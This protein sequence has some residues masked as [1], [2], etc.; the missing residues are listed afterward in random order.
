MP[1]H[2]QSQNPSSIASTHKA[3]PAQLPPRR[4]RQTLS[5]KF[6]QA[7]PPNTVESGPY[8]AEEIV[9]KVKPPTIYTT[10][11]RITPLPTIPEITPFRIQTPD[12]MILLLR[13]LS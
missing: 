6:Y 10:R 4:K 7:K 1:H 9:S 13:L 2:R 11:Q 8:L 12:H 3:S 5:N